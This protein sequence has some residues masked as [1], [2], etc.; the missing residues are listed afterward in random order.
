[1]LGAKPRQ[2]FK[3]CITSQRFCLFNHW[4]MSLD[5]LN[6]FRQ[7]DVYWVLTQVIQGK[8]TPVTG[9]AGPEGSRKLRL[10]EFL[11]TK[12]YKGSPKISGTVIKHVFKIFVQVWN[13]G[14]LQTTP[15]WLNAVIPA[16][17]PLLETLSQIFNGN[18][19]KGCQPFSLSL[20]STSKM[21]PFQILL[22][23]WVKKKSCKEQGLANRG[24]WDTTTILCLV[25]NCW[26]LKAVWVVALSWCKNQSPL[27]QC[28]E[29]FFS[30]T[31]ANLSAHSSKT[32][33]MLC[34]LDE[35]TACELSHQHQE[36][37][38]T[39]SWHEWTCRAFFGLGK[40]GDFRWLD[41]CFDT[42]S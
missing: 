27:C 20:C 39:L 40:F 17:L 11:T 16:L 14:L 21:P 38:S 26:T 33:D 35:Q 31:H 34:V 32:A 6:I 7:I 13:S 2:S 29:C 25:K 10:L 22:H 3:I 12:W 15:L 24:G 4:R 23:P 37:K 19:V 9:H 18:A 42:E 28:S 36:E 30:G 8:S 1:M 5:N 41:R